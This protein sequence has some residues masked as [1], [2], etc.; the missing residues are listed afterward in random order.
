MSFCLYA[1]QSCD[2]FAVRPGRVRRATLPAE[3]VL[4]KFVERLENVHSSW[5]AD[6]P[7]QN[8]S[9]IDTYNTEI[10]ISW[11]FRGLRGELQ[12][13]YL[14]EKTRL[15][16]IRQNSLHGIVSVPDLPGGLVEIVLDMNKFSGALSFAELPS[17]LDTLTLSWNRCRGHVDLT[18]LPLEIYTLHLFAN[19][20]SGDLRLDMLPRTLSDL[21]LHYNRFYGKFL[22]TPGADISG[23]T[24]TISTHRRLLL[25]KL[26]PPNIEIWDSLS[27]DDEER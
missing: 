11:C 1:A 12:W 3:Y 2:T 8:W 10:R 16:N 23:V 13:M 20:F 27:R 18:N 21:Q 17:T 4:C 7:V 14:P 24:I 19:R 25:P 26:I 5:N 6:T 9:G 15:L 22:L